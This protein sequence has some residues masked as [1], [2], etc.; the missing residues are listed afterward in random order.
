MKAWVYII[1][2]ETSGRYYCGQ[3]ANVEQRLR[4]HNDPEYRLSKTTKRFQGPWALVW[5]QSCQDLSEATRL[6]RRVKNRGIARFLREVES[7]ESRKG[8]PVLTGPQ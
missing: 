1:Q 6:E 8:E 7:A 5:A 3:S 4:Q 2:S